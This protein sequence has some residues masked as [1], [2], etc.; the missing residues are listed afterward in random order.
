M[1]ILAESSGSGRDMT[2]VRQS[3]D[4]AQILR[5]D[6]AAV[7][8]CSTVA[9]A[10]EPFVTETGRVDTRLAILHTSPHSEVLERMSYYGACDEARQCRSVHHFEREGS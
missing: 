4:E 5:D 3:R 1:Q 9:G 2:R 6:S 8:F 7:R 10:S